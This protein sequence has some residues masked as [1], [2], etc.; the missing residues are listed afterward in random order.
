M[1]APT[2]EIMNGMGQACR[3]LGVMTTTGLGALLSS[4]NVNAPFFMVGCFDLFVVIMTLAL[5]CAGRLR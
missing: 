2:R 5:V 3:A 4:I 1:I